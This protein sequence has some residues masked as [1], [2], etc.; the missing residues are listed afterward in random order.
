MSARRR[1]R[2]LG[3]VVSAGG[4]P[5][6]GGQ[7][8]VS[9]GGAPATAGAAMDVSQWEFSS[10]L[11]AG[12]E[13]TVPTWE[14]SAEQGAAGEMTVPT[15]EFSSDLSIGSHISGT[16]EASWSADSR[17]GTPD[18]DLWGDA[19]VNNAVGQTG[20]NFGNVD[21][22]QLN[23]IATSVR[24]A[25]IKVDLRGFSATATGNAHTITLRATNQNVATTAT[26]TLSAGGNVSSP[27][28]ESTITNNNAPAVPTAV[29]ITSAAIPAST[30]QD[31]TFTLTDA[32]MNQL[33]GTWALI[34]LTTNS[35]LA[36]VNVNSREN[37]T[38]SNR[39]ALNFTLLGNA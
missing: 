21:P 30:T 20:T 13:A 24:R 18:S 27:F 39:M 33:L 22:L 16:I 38:V 15:W 29:V 17:S 5:G 14:F 19:Y 7:I 32:Q 26:I 3:K 1:I 37:A 28:T 23:N 11:T 10:D 9:D 34:V 6:S 2:T 31:V 35:V 36:N 25:F 8:T 4:T 12:A